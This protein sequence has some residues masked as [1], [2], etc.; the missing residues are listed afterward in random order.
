MLQGT[1]GRWVAAAGSSL[2]LAA[3]LSLG[4]GQGPS[5]VE[6]KAEVLTRHGMAQAA[7]L[8]IQ[9]EIARMPNDGKLHILLGRTQL[10]LGDYASADSAFRRACVLDTNFVG[11]MVSAYIGEGR[12]RLVAGDLERAKWSLSRAAEA[13]PSA[14]ARV[15][16]TCLAA[17]ARL[18]DTAPQ[19]ADEVFGL[20]AGYHPAINEKIGLAWLE[21]GRLALGVAPA[22]GQADLDRAVSWAPA[23]S[24]EAG[25]A[26]ASAMQKS[27]QA[28]REQLAPL[29]ERY[30][31]GGRS[32]FMAASG[33]SR[34]RRTVVV[35]VAGGWV[36]SGFEV[37][38]GDT[39][40][41]EP[42]G[43][44]RAEARHQGWVSEPCGP[45]GWPAQS[46]EWLEGGTTRL[47]L[48]S[49]PRMALIGR[50]GNERPFAVSRSIFLVAAQSGQLAFAVNEF[51][52]K[53]ALAQGHFAVGIE[54][55]MRA[56]RP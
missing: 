29:V 25:K 39:L 50:I 44:V 20:A 2:T 41:L 54:A 33:Q 15:A 14:A 9:Q 45:A 48:A 13:D 46:M 53:V 6:R 23:L 32:G 31:E 27:D 40:G 17:G 47:P 52:D 51:P 43:S 56:L 42:T 55:P 35:S 3:T 8:L 21:A 18:I 37:Q 4:C 24:R 12:T 22:R 34:S 11:P 26:V 10:S 5:A 19:R 1:A 38:T 49:S 7:V 30:G 28:T 16:D 36:A